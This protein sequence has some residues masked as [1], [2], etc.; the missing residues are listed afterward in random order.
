M[1]V[2]TGEPRQIT[3]NPYRSADPVWSPDGERIAF[4]GGTG[5]EWHLYVVN[6]DDS[7]QKQLTTYRSYPFM[8]DLAWSPHDDHI[9]FTSPGKDG[10]DAEIFVVAADSGLVRQLTDN[11]YAQDWEPEWSPDGTR[12]VYAADSPDGRREIFVMDAD[13]DNVQ[14]LTHKSGGRE[15][16]L[17]N[18]WPVWSP[19]GERIAF[20]SNN[21]NR[22]WAIFVMDA[23]GGNLLQLTDSTYIARWPVWLPDSSRIAFTREL[24]R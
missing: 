5:N 9:A 14:R 20:N 19:D 11:V 10:R 7:A 21:T 2:D 1:D 16:W 3:Y 18:A 8:R 4:A 23:D 24:A 17:N 15:E 22:N 12:I 6:E 13:G